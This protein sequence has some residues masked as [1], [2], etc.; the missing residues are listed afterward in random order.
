MSLKTLNN[1]LHT[2]QN[3]RPARNKE[4]CGTLFQHQL[5][6][7]RIFVVSCSEESSQL[8]SHKTLLKIKGFIRKTYS[9]YLTAAPQIQRIF[10]HKIRAHLLSKGRYI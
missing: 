10:R 6:K 1:A 4:L 7:I 8:P 9:Q 5:L 2:E 3:R